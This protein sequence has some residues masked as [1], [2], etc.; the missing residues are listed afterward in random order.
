MLILSKLQ[1]VPHKNQPRLGL[2]FMAYKDEHCRAPVHTEIIQRDLV[3]QSAAFGRKVSA[4]A[5]PVTNEVNPLCLDYFLQVVTDNQT[6]VGACHTLSSGIC[7]Y[8]HIDNSLA[9]CDN[10]FVQCQSDA[11]WASLSQ[12]LGA[13][14]GIIRNDDLSSLY[15]GWKALLCRDIPHSVIKFYMYERLKQVYAMEYDDELSLA[16]NKDSQVNT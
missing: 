14:I 3:Q 6:K 5:I 12:L 10:A 11:N 1:P 15:A 7:A 4:F 16:C 13:L 8:Y 2:T 9:T